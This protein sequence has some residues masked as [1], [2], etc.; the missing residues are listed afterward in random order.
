MT[1]EQNM[2]NKE[3]DELLEQIP[4]YHRG[5][6]SPAQAHKLSLLLK[7]NGLFRAE[8][9]REQVMVDSLAAM[10]EI[11]LPRGLVAHAVK[12]AVGES[13]TASW[14]SMDTLLVALGVGVGCAATAQFLSGKVEFLPTIG[15]WL[16][17][18][19]G[20]AV[21]GSLGN[22]VGG[23][24]IVSAALVLGGVFW[25]VRALRSRD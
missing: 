16:G 11:P 15:G 5:E 8:A 4:A 12:E 22:F 3:F 14:F 20:V 2:Q 10:P 21:S 13:A 9:A 7:E 1:T 24:G 23:V 19:A 25:T 6:L 18:L 17:D